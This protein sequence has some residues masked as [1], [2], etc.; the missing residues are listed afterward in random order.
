VGGLSGLAG[1]GGLPFLG[2]T[3]PLRGRLQR[4]RPIAAVAAGPDGGYAVD[5]PDAGET[6]LV[7]IG[8]DDAAT[9]WE[10]ELLASGRQFRM[11]RR[12]DLLLAMN[13]RT[14]IVTEAGFVADSWRRTGATEPVIADGIAYLRTVRGGRTF[15]EALE[16]ETGA[17]A[18]SVQL[19]SPELVPATQAPRAVTEEL[20]ILS[21]VRR[22]LRARTIPAGEP[23]WET[24]RA[25]EL[26]IAT[27]GDYVYATAPADGARA[28]HRVS[29]ADGQSTRIDTS[30]ADR[31][32]PVTVDDSLIVRHEGGNATALVGRDPRT[33]SERWRLADALTHRDW[34][35]SDALLAR[36]PGS[37]LTELDP[38]TGS[39]RWTTGEVTAPIV[40]LAWTT[41]LVAVARRGTLRCRDRS[42]GEVRWQVSVP[43]A[44]SEA[45]LP[46]VS[47]T[48]DAVIHAV[49]DT[50]R[51]YSVEA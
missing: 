40:D 7:G 37:R 29:A 11:W 51:V 24:D 50:V 8:L 31:V 42:D 22:P 27:A 39:R 43:Q 2:E 35:R 25:F 15:A 49:G 48:D 19:E 41:E 4:D 33:A 21:D 18:W 14:L 17:P 12:G 46:T 32:V 36:L 38:R 6:T 13:G 10:R 34:L 5:V 28:L 30:S 1:C 16:L 20:V 23:R 3:G 44:Q 26:A 9:R 45:Q 47:A